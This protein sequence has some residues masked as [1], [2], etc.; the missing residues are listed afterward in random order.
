MSDR[1]IILEAMKDELKEI[2]PGNTN[3]T[4]SIAEVK[5]GYYGWSDAINKPLVCVVM[6]TDDVDIDYI[7][8]GQIRRMYTL[9]YGFMDS[10]HINNYDKVHSL[11]RDIEYW[12]KYDFS[13]KSNTFVKK[14]SIVEG[15]V[16]SPYS[17]FEINT[18]I[19]YNQEL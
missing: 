11:V 3:Y 5:R 10:D 8:S 2:Q 4:S 18:E 19:V 1:D 17:Y 14:I 13:H 6:L 12:L 9:V 16:A 15:G 7:P